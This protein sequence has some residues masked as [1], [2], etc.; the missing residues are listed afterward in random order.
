VFL[1]QGEL[2]AMIEFRRHFPGITDNARA[3]NCAKIIAGWQPP[4]RA[5]GRVIPLRSSRSR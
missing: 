1:E 2:P 5:P 3:R 4:A